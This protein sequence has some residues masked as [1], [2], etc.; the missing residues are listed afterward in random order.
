M[1]DKKYEGRTKHHWFTI[2]CL[3]SSPVRP[4]FTFTLVKS[5]VLCTRCCWPE[6]FTG[7]V[8][9]MPCLHVLWTICVWCEVHIQSMFLAVFLVAFGRSKNKQ[10]YRNIE[11][12]GVN[13]CTVR[14]LMCSCNLSTRAVMG[15]S[16]VTKKFVQGNFVE[17]NK[18]A[19]GQALRKAVNDQSERW[20]GRSARK[21]GH[22]YTTT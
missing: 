12:D 16:D 21:N 10:R 9:C 19:A 11:S 18:E 1:L 7:N 3:I 8:C 2:A 17:P 6:L 20:L 14:S 15:Q 5:L 4:F 13:H 22:K